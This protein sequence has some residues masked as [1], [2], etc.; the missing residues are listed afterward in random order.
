MAIGLLV[1][2]QI[3]ASIATTPLGPTP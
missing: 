2:L 1:A 3:Q